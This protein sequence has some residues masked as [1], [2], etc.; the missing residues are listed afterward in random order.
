MD[1]FSLIKK[2][3]QKFTYNFPFLGLFSQ[4]NIFTIFIKVNKYDIMNLCC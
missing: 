2:L 4:K 1:L 3:L